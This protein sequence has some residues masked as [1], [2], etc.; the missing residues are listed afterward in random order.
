MIQDLDNLINQYQAELDKLHADKAEYERQ[1]I[2]YEERLR[3]LN[4]QLDTE[5]G[6]H[7]P[8]QINTIKENLETEINQLRQQYE[9]LR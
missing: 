7:D 3:Q 6:T 1:K 8:E 2:I 4:E 5:F 9:E